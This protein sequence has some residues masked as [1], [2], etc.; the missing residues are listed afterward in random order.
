MDAQLTDSCRWLKLHVKQLFWAALVWEIWLIVIVPTFQQQMK[1]KKK[2]KRDFVSNLSCWSSSQAAW[3]LALRPC[4]FLPIVAD[5]D[6]VSQLKA[7][8]TW[9]CARS[10]SSRREPLRWWR[11]SATEAADPG[12]RPGGRLPTDPPP[13]RAVRSLQTQHWSPRRRW[14][15]PPCRPPSW[16]LVPTRSFT[17]TTTTDIHFVDF[18]QLISL[19]LFIFFAA[20]LADLFPLICESISLFLFCWFAIVPQTP[21]H[22]TRNYDKPW[23]TNSKPSTPLKSSDSFG[24]QGSSS[25]VESC[26]A[27]GLECFTITTQLKFKTPPASGLFF[28]FLRLSLCWGHFTVEPLEEI[29]L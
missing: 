29:W 20:I 23:L 10:S 24:S 2:K 21:Q 19:E 16:S 6:V 17:T 22:I 15:A 12:R 14:A 3:K 5:L 7:G 26:T 28:L 13:V 18:P 4:F 11:A 1:K 8:P 25:E 27:H 9:S